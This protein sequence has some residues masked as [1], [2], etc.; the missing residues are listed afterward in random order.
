MP[1]YGLVSVIAMQ[2]GDRICVHSACTTAPTGLGGQPMRFVD[3][4][5]WTILTDTV[6]LSL[7][8][9]DHRADADARARSM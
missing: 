2:S 9:S 8:H 6:V 4:L 3:A 7:V 5:P 1:A